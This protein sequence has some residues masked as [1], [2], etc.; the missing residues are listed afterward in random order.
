M[1]NNICVLVIPAGLSFLLQ[2]CDVGLFKNMKAVWREV[3]RYWLRQVKASQA[4]TH[5]VFNTLLNNLWEKLE[6]S[7]AKSGMLSIM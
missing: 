5:R 4:I 7:W 1:A 6:R 3:F 2:P